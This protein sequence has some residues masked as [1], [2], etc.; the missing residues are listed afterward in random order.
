MPINRVYLENFRLFKKKDLIFSKDKNFIQG[1][2]GSGKTSV[3]ESIEMLFTGKSFRTSKSK[4]CISHSSDS[5][6]ISLSGS[7]LDQEIV[8][9]GSN[10][11]NGR[12]SFS[13]KLNDKTTKKSSIYFLQTILAKNLR[14]IEGEPDLRRDHLNNLMFHVKPSSYKKYIDYNKILKQRNRC[15]KQKLNQS[16]ISVWT[17]QLATIGVS[18]SKDQHAFFNRFRDILTN[19]LNLSAEDKR[20]NFLEGADIKFIKGWERSKSLLSSLHESIDKDIAIGY[21][22]Q[23]PHRMDCTYKIN[24]KK[25]SS[26]LSRGQL[27]VLILLIFLINHNLINSFVESDTVLLIDDLG[28]ELDLENLDLVLSNI[29]K[30]PN[31]I[32]LTGIKGEDLEKLVLNFSNFKRINL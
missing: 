19:S 17:K 6:H 13:R 30:A 8:L 24:G 20:L 1:L 22:S 7:Y 10:K 4:D 26:I 11:I 3:L 15:L 2:N 32:I 23:G 25:A 28:S 18:L 14:M 12:L 16:E 9:K 5:F 21:T 31:Q 27:K 29:S